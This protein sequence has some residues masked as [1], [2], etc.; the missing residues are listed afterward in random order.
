M[1][2]KR[3]DEEIVKT[4]Q[5]GDIQSLGVLIE[6]YEFKIKRYGKKFLGS[7]EDIEDA[8]QEIFTK[9]YFNIQNFDTE[10]NFSSWIYRIAHNE[11]INLIKKNKKNPLLF[12]DPDILFPHPISRENTDKG[13]IEAEIKKSMDLCLEK[14]PPKYREPMIL[15]YLEDK[16][17]K[18]ISDIIRIP[19]STVGVRLK[20]GKEILKSICNNLKLNYE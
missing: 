9:A 12:F 13:P 5:S 19:V 4:I 20:R 6:R 2:D 11:F 16:N 18:E 7:A 1:E 15:Y 17:Y 14:M 3:T 8:V 10:K